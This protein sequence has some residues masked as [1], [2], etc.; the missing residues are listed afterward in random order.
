MAELA[1]SV[2]GLTGGVEP[3]RTGRREPVV[4]T[5]GRRGQEIGQL[6]IERVVSGAASRG[7]E[8]LAVRRPA[9]RN[10]STIREFHDAGFGRGPGFRLRHDA[11]CQLVAA[12]KR[13]WMRLHRMDV[14]R[15]SSC[16]VPLRG[17]ASILGGM[18]LM[19]A[20]CN[21]RVLYAS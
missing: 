21:N 2:V 6:L 18:D 20:G 5:A 15:V 19:S 7:H 9:A 10:I 1:G 8:Y 13:S 12:D 3:G 11:R 16:I 14:L 4:V 17:P